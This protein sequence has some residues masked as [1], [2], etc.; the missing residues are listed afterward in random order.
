MRYKHFDKQNIDVSSLATGTWAIGGSGYGEVDDQSSIDSI[1][2]M[3]EGGVN[4]IDTAPNYGAGYSEKIVGQAIKGLDRSKIL[5]STKAAAS[6]LTL[7][8]V[9]TGAR[10]S[11]DGSYA[12]LLYECEQSLRRLGTDYIDFY[13]MH[14]P[15]PETPVEE[16]MEAMNTL[17]KQGK[18]RFVGLSNYNKEQIMEAQKYCDIE[19]M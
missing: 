2:A 11:N 12:N 4:L 17:K 10:Y 15:D 5:I 3:F 7:K 14:W 6:P 16:T 1:R 8:A 19:V 9:R 18:I 13:F